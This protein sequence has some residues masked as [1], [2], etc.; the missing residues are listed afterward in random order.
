MEAERQ[1]IVR[2]DLHADHRCRNREQR[3]ADLRPGSVQGKS[4]KGGSCQSGEVENG[5][6]FPDISIFPPAAVIIRPWIAGC[7][8]MWERRKYIQVASCSGIRVFAGCGWSRCWALSAS[9]P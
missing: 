6:A 1:G 7:P 9:W 8:A 5:V 4:G 3:S 2:A